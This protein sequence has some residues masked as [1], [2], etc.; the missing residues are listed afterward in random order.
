[1]RL[2]Y[3]VSV[4]TATFKKHSITGLKEQRAGDLGNALQAVSGV[5]PSLLSFP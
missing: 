4:C 2:T 3:E 5:S 1:M